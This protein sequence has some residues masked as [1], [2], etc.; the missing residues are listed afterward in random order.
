MKRYNAIQ[1]VV[2]SFFSPSF[3]RDVGQH[4][5]GTGFGYLFVLL[6]VLWIPVTVKW[7]GSITAFVRDHTPALINQIPAITISH[8][9]VSADCVMP[10]TIKE[11]MSQQP[12]L[13]IDT[14]GATTSLKDAK[15]DMLLTRTKL[16]VRKTPGETREYDLSQV[17]NF[18]LDRNRVQHWANEIGQNLAAVLYPFILIVSF[19]YRMIQALIYALIGMLF[20]RLVNATLEYTAL[21][22]LTVFALTPVLILCTA[23]EI[24]TLPLVGWW[25][26]CLIVAMVYLFLAV[27]ANAGIPAA[28]TPVPPPPVNG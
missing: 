15:A 21:V 26:I 23:Q 17:D 2:L 24:L 18:K 9:A 19:L 11:P 13:V 5:R 10:Y 7:H 6:L 3:Y 4:W 14:T 28:K 25:F 8:G 20:A 22:R 1:A 27:K 16:I 12:L